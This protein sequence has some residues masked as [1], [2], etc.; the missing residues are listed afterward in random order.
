MGLGILKKGVKKM[1][2]EVTIPNILVLGVK[3]G[4]K[5]K[6]LAYRDSLG[7]HADILAYRVLLE[8]CGHG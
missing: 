5:S 7:N 2:L 6:S 8:L 1:L 4:S 3:L